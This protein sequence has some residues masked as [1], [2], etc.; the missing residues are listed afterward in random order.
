MNISM[1]SSLDH[2]FEELIIKM[3][4]FE[5]KA[6]KA[7]ELEKEVAELKALLVLRDKTIEALNKELDSR[8]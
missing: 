2:E 6:I 1:I 8:D 3:N 4:N 5:K 7:D